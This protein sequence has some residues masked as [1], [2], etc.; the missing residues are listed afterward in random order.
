MKTSTLLKLS[1]LVGL[2]LVAFGIVMYMRERKSQLGRT[3]Y[4]AG[5]FAEAPVI[6]EYTSNGKTMTLRASDNMTIQERI[7]SIQ[8]MIEKSVMDPEIRSLAMKIT[9]DCPERDGKCEAK[10]IYKFIKKNVRYTGDIAPIKMSN[11]QTEGID[12]YQSA[13]RTLEMGGG[14]CDDQV[15]VFAALA[16]SVGLTT[17]LRVTAE[18]AS[19][20]DC[21]DAHIYPVVMLPKFAPEYAVAAD[22]TLPG[23][24]NF[25]VEAPAGRV[26]D[27]D[28]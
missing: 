28:A 22:T 4:M 13:R 19:E 12:L 5:R 27:Y 25:G 11:G 14:D 15:G 8:K 10:A 23:S 20:A 3:R 2:G 18:C 6:D 16:S 21:D 26:T 7:G 24:F 9:A 1:G 17:R